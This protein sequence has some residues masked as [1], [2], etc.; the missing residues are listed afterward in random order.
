MSDNE[1]DLGRTDH[2][3]DLLQYP[4]HRVVGV[5]DTEERTRDAVDAL[6]SGGFLTTE[7]GIGTGPDLA[8][9][10]RQTTGRSGFA[11]MAM[12]FNEAL[13]MPNDEAE[14]KAFY[15]GAMRDS[16]Y[17]VAVLAPTGERKERA[18]EILSS[19]GAHDIGYFGRLVIEKLDS[20]MD[21]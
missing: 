16:R 20:K 14:A 3:L 7:I 6:T 17:V 12:R 8:N 4:T 15:E 9:R 5:L 13:G 1:H 21:R 2:S 18:L 19:H 11:D 10:L